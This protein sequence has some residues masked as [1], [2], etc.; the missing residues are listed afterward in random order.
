MIINKISNREVK[1]TSGEKTITL[2][3][4]IHAAY[5]LLDFLYDLF[6]FYGMVPGV[7]ANKK[8]DKPEYVDMKGNE[9]TGNDRGDEIVILIG[10]SEIAFPLLDFVGALC[11]DIHDNMYAWIVPNYEGTKRRMGEEGITEYMKAHPEILK[12]KARCES[13]LDSLEG[14]LKRTV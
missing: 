4:E 5:E 12:E 14:I 1:L 10:G 7:G 8:T 11:S 6:C 2:S 3:V 9:M 13:L